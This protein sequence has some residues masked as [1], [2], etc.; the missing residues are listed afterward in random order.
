[1][2]KECTHCDGLGEV[3]LG[4]D[5]YDC[6]TITCGYCDG[7]GKVESNFVCEELTQ[8]LCDNIMPSVK[9]KPQPGGIIHGEI[10]S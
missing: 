2:T 4:H 3:P 1:M 8:E 9:I 5:G 10:Q 6:V 7:T